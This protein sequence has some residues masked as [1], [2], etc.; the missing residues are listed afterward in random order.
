M[1]RLGLGLPGPKISPKPSNGSALAPSTGP[2]DKQPSYI[3]CK[4]DGKEL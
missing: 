3:P 4:I 2:N 1:I